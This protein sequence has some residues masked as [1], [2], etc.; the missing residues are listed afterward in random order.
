MRLDA[1]QL[2]LN[3]FMKIFTLFELSTSIHELNHSFTFNVLKPLL[4]CCILHLLISSE[5]HKPIECFTFNL[6]LNML[7]NCFTSLGLP[8]FTLESFT[9]KC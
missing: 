2:Y 3:G 8:T 6:Y 9:L 1:L 7:V 5:P 4:K